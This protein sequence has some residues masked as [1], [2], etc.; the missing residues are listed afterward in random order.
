M[1]ISNCR[2]GRKAEVEELDHE[3]RNWLV[4][5]QSWNCWVGAAR[6]TEINAIKIWNKIMEKTND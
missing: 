6:A 4:R 1:K 3:Y 5:C 2:C